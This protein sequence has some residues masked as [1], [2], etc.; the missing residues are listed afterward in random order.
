[1]LDKQLDYEEEAALTFSGGQPLS[2]EAI[3]GLVFNKVLASD[4]REWLLPLHRGW[5]AKVGNVFPGL[6]PALAGWLK[7][8]GRARLLKERAA[9]G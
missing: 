5:L 9:K 1:M 7:R 3:A 4:K 8:T 6:T 2:V